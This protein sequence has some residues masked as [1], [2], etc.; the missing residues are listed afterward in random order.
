[1]VI[2]I[3]GRFLHRAK[4]IIFIGV[5]LA[6]STGRAFRTPGQYQRHDCTEQ[7]EWQHADG[8]TTRNP[9]HQGGA[10]AVGKDTTDR[11]AHGDEPGICL[12]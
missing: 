4:V 10:A 3:I 9:G 11:H 6:T 12:L 7:Q 2:H 1:M 8:K 5:A